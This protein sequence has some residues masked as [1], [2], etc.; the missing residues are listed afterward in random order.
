MKKKIF[1]TIV[2]AYLFIVAMLYFFPADAQSHC[3]GG[4]DT[5]IIKS[6]KNKK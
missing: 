3:K 1:W 2:F 4:H 6:D 5:I